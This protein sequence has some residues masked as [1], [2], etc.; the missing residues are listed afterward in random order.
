M[1]LKGKIV[2]PKK[3]SFTK[4]KPFYKE[5]FCVERYL[6]GDG[7]CDGDSGGPVVSDDGLLVG[8]IA[9][10]DEGIRDC[11]YNDIMV[12]VAYYKSWIDNII[13]T[14]FAS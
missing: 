6:S 9:A 7:V 2:D 4:R 12:N 10:S 1:V 5:E 13:K 14:V 8:V 3:C 11:K